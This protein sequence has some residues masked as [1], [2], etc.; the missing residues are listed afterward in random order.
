MPSSTSKELCNFYNTFC[1]Y[2]AL[3]S[4]QAFDGYCEFK[5]FLDHRLKDWIEVPLTCVVVI[6]SAI[7]IFI[8]I[9]GKID[10]TFKWCVMNIAIL[11]LLWPIFYRGLNGFVFLKIWP[12]ISRSQSMSNL[13]NA[14]L[15]KGEKKSS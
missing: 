14:T 12:L 11:H 13:L 15:G 3:N 4:T 8:S 1:L 10:G 6:L 5:D 2:K 9:Y 7:I